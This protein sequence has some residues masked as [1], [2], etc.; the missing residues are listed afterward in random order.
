MC[1]TDSIKM[2]D[3]S[4]A[5]KITKYKHTSTAN[6][7]Y[8]SLYEHEDMQRTTNKQTNK[9]GESVHFILKHLNFLIIQIIL[10]NK[11]HI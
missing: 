5:K 10:R 6:T 11:Y 8:L 2:R 3:N 9:H 7:G 4:S 1:V